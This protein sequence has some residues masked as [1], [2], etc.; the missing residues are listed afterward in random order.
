MLELR[1]NIKHLNERV[2]FLNPLMLN[3]FK[4]HEFPIFHCDDEILYISKTFTL[5]YLYPGLVF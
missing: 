4:W 2:E 1:P 5:F 3:L